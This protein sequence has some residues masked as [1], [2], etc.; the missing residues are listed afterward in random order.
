MNPFG[1]GSSGA[2]NVSSGTQNLALD[3]K[4]QFTTLNVSS[5]ATLST[6]STSGSVLYI[7]ATQSIVIDG[8]IN[9]SNKVLNGQRSW[10]VVI[11]GDTYST[12]SVGQGGSGDILPG[13]TIA[14]GSQGNGGGGGGGDGAGS[15][16]AI[17]GN[18][19]AGNN[20]AGTGG[21]RIVSDRTGTAFEVY[22]RGNNG[23]N[24]AGGSGA[25]L[26]QAQTLAGTTIR[27]TATSGKGANAYGQNGEDGVTG[28]QSRVSG[29]AAYSY[30][31]RAM[32]GG[33]SGG[34]AGKSGV[35]VV[36]VAPSVT[37]NGTVVTSGTNGGNGGNGGRTRSWAGLDNRYGMGAG[38]G[39][40]GN[41]GNV[42]IRYGSSLV[43]AGSYTMAGGS[44]GSGGVG[45]DG[46]SYT[47][48]S[49]TFGT[50]GTKSSIAIKPTADFT[51]SPTSG[52]RPLT[53]SFTNKSLGATSYSWDFGDSTGSS[54]EN[55]TKIYT[56]VGTYTV[57]LTSSN[58]AGDTTVTKT[59]LI[60]TTA[61]I[62]TRSISGTLSF[63]GGANRK[64]LA[65]RSISGTLSFS[66]Y[67]RAVVLRDAEGLQDKRY[68][69]K[70]YDP[71][72]N[73][74]EVWKDVASDLE[75]THEVN[76]I[77]STTTI[78]LAR[79]S[80]TVGVTV[81]P[82]QTESG[83]NITTEDDFDLLVAT[84]SR[85]QVGSGSSVDYNNRVD[86]TVFYGS[87]EPLYTE[88]MQE[89]LTEDDENLLA[90]LGAP[91]G[92]RIFTGF[93]SDINSRY[94]STE[95]TIVQ[96]TSF[97]WDTDQFPITT[98]GGA[99]T[100]PFLS[101]DPSQI[102]RDAV[103]KFVADS[104]PYNTYTH[105]TDSS[106]A[107]TGTV[108][109]Y[110]F[111]SNTYKETFD[112]VLEL[113]PSNWY[114][115]IG[116]G[117][118][119]VYYNE[120]STTPEHLFYLGKHIKSL[121]LKGSI[122][123]SVNRVLFTGGGDPALYISREE[124]PAD[125]TRRSLQVMSD[126]RVT[127]LSSAEIIAEGNIGDNNKRLFR[128]TVEIL[129]KQYDIESIN[130]GDTVGFRNFGNEVDGLLMQVIGLSYSPDS[131]QLQ[132]DTKP[133]TISKRLED[134]VRN[135]KVTENMNV[136]GTPS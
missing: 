83:L 17:G 103:D 133:P 128:T 57:S 88:D 94:G 102:A 5:G 68:L 85:N 72:G 120:R 81:S 124:P 40:G 8:A 110:T 18:G 29:P 98:S 39:G 38:G 4:H 24:S 33:G 126:A 74:I 53:V 127:V 119:V 44:P 121:D 114:Y 105:K 104:S 26:V 30:N 16:L 135:L 52:T 63:G 95:T 107:T 113:M 47:A 6:G 19:G 12:P 50:D 49:G 2:L 31:W 129:S 73:Y 136:P 22:T 97:G 130:V 101:Q 45:G 87:V 99:T 123:N 91:N 3:V 55:P 108:V 32:G 27:V 10:S 71:E 59:N 1:D 36:L 62:F 67:A 93:I 84:E 92:R 79:N 76:T 58:S 21:T 51:A 117:D 131:V 116:L 54:V 106:I 11:D 112:K 89:I 28:S 111:R 61:N 69:Y 115:R 65:L 60:V 42:T 34:Q 100:V 43:D 37:I 7:T 9:V 90:E 122:L 14:L 77:G 132:L 48:S 66:G 15:P 118:N 96:L 75:F 109:S 125:R 25:T 134:V 82:L 70:V 23:T 64:F 13:Q 35:H 80:D 78:E 41:A 46:Q 20:T 86:V 56:S